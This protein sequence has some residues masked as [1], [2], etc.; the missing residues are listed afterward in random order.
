MKRS[1]CLNAFM[2]CVNVNHRAPVAA[3]FDRQGFFRIPSS[4]H[5][6]N[7]KNGPPPTSHDLSILNGIS[8]PRQSKTCQLMDMT[9][10]LWKSKK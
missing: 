8:D 10:K 9:E 7:I 5:G 6:H 3:E 2:D 1:E 4:G